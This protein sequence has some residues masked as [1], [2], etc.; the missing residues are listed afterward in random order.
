MSLLTL[1]SKFVNINKNRIL[2]DLNVLDIS[3]TYGVTK[4][5][6]NL[7]DKVKNRLNDGFEILSNGYDPTENGNGFEFNSTD[8]L[9]TG[10][11]SKY[12]ISLKSF[13]IA[14][15][16][17]IDT[18]AA[19]GS[20]IF[21]LGEDISGGAGE[22]Y[23]RLR[24]STAEDLTLTFKTGRLKVDNDTFMLD[25]WHH[26][27]ITLEYSDSLVLLTHALGVWIDGV[28][29][30][31]DVS[32]TGN[33]VTLIKPRFCLGNFGRILSA[34]RSLTG[35]LDDFYF[36]NG[37]AIVSSRN[38]T[39]GNNTFTPPARN[40]YKAFR[41]YI[42]PIL[43][44]QSNTLADQKIL[45]DGSN[46]VKQWSDVMMK[47]IFYGSSNNP[48]YDLTKQAVY[49][50]GSEFVSDINGYDDFDFGTD[51]FTIEFYVMVSS[52][53]V[54]KWFF[55]TN[56]GTGFAVGQESSNNYIRL[57]IEGNSY[58]IAISISIDTWYHVRWCREGGVLKGFMNG[59]QGYSA[60][61]S[62]SLVNAGV[63]IL[64][65]DSD[66][67]NFTGWLDNLTI[68]NYSKGLNSFNPKPRNFPN[69]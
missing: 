17:Y 20:V 57:N 4:D 55:G 35:N 69:L 36:V 62:V 31:K 26:V 24:S 12:N 41:T 11:S 54:N 52:I 5:G 45:L 25:T 63:L 19:S 28:L 15:W 42:E 44:L 10:I 23:M 9:K 50:D 47:H 38:L 18:I 3:S 2:S 27:M 33:E 37:K 21:T 59:V 68:C 58:D 29:T 43:Q 13:T 48:S 6:S 61:N 65:K 8:N 22:M 32:D 56:D 60:S 39:V 67:D 51:D 1:N 64:G 53:N 16:V 46:N 34:D 7:V 49:F 14:F 66:G 30:Y 40:D